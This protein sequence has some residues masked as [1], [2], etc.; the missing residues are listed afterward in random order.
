MAQGCQDPNLKKRLD[1]AG[2][3]TVMLSHLIRAVSPYHD[4]K[5]AKEIA[6]LIKKEKPDIVH[7]NSTKAGLLGS[8]IAFRLKVP[9]VVFTA[10]GWIFNEP[11]ALKALYVWAEKFGA[12]HK[13][14]II[15]VSEFDRVTAIKHKIGKPGQLVT[16][17]N[18]I[19]TSD[20]D[21]PQT[22]DV[23]KSRKEKRQELSLRENI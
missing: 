14:K 16:I 13:D 17:H 10:H 11:G 23:D 8:W 9:K 3:R 5:A 21:V 4:L 20:V 2:V 15:C 22:S 18:G 6:D 12:H 1:T 19:K 7:T